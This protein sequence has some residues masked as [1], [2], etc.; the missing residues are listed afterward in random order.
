MRLKMG[1][2]IHLCEYETDSLAEKLIAFL[3]MKW[4]LKELNTETN[5]RW[6]H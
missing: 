1:K 4:K 2:K 5:K 3:K 6:I